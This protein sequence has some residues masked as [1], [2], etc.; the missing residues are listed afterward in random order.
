MAIGIQ[1]DNG[2]WVQVALPPAAASGGMAIDSYEVD[3]AEAY[4][5]ITRLERMRAAV[6]HHAYTPSTH[7]LMG[8]ILLDD[9]GAMES[10]SQS[11]ALETISDNIRTKVRDWASKAMLVLGNLVSKIKYRITNILDRIFARKKAIDERAVPDDAG[12]RAAKMVPSPRT[13]LVATAA[14]VA[15][16]GVLTYA[17]TSAPTIGADV[18]GINR[19]VA[20][21]VGR[22]RSV[23]IPGWSL[24][25]SATSSISSGITRYVITPTKVAGEKL[26]SG[27]EWSGAKLGSVWTSVKSGLINIANTAWYSKLSSKVEAI[28]SV[29]DRVGKFV[30]NEMK[31]PKFG[32]V[33]SK[34]L[35][36]PYYF[37]LTGL[38]L[39]LIKALYTAAKTAALLLWETVSALWG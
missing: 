22:L 33:L 23:R 25:T 3:S 34:G 16:G 6:R 1:L 15:L 11:V 19:F 35:S 9:G 13:I 24:V 4:Q 39:G 38:F 8:A 32:E 7:A 30:G 31:S 14:A 27:A 17:L 18:T 36:K 21:V 28:L 37:V 2:E 20:N 10:Y 12:R 26:V 29:P 5:E